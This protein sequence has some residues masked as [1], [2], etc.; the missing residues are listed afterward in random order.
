MKI[1]FDDF[2]V[3]HGQEK[4]NELLR[5]AKPTLDLHVEEGTSADLIL[6][7]LT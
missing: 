2:L 3:K 4:F 1:G 5:K 6:S 7:E